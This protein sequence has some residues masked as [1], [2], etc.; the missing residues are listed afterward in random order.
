MIMYSLYLYRHPHLC[1]CYNS[2]FRNT[3]LE[4]HVFSCTRITTLSQRDNKLSQ[5]QAADL[6]QEG[7]AHSV[8]SGHQHLK[9]RHAL[10]ICE[11]R[12]HSPPLLHVCHHTLRACLHL[13][14]EVKD[15]SSGWQ[16]HKGGQLGAHKGREGLVGLMG[17]A[18]SQTPDVGKGKELRQD[19]L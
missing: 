10:V 19:W 7:V 4:E 5:A 13:H 18:A 9:V 17:E 14:K 16:L 8:H 1:P 15:R 12:Q 2:W 6:E 11:G 3:L